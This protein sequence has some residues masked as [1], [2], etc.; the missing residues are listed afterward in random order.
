METDAQS[1]NI[2]SLLKFLFEMGHLKQTPRSGW[3]KVG[4]K[5][6]ETVA[7]H[8]YRTAIIGLLLAK[9][10]NSQPERVALFCLFHDIAEA[11]TLDLDW[12]AQ[13]YYEKS[14]YIDKKV[15]KDQLANLPN[16]LRNLIGE[17][18]DCYSSDSDKIQVIARDADLLEA[19]LQA[20]Q[21]KVQGYELAEEWI[22]S[23]VELLETEW[24][25][26]IGQK[27]LKILKDGRSREQVWWWNGLNKKEF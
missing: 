4:I 25:Q 9:L 16:S 26:K 21:Y 1:E 15:I 14:D 19:S 3:Y 2:D 22:T 8:S 24:G 18:L 27:L 7:E 12:L 10:E 23:S 13:N 6:P 5:N 20:L 11:R 17:L